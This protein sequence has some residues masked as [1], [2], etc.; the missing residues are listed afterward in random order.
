MAAKVDF[1]RITALSFDCYGTLIDWETG[2]RGAL[3]AKF[4]PVPEKTL[5]P[6][7]AEAEARE[8]ARTPGKPYPL[9]LEAVYRAL[10]VRFDVTITQD[11]AR[12]L[13]ASIPNWPAFKDSAD[14]LKR[15]QRR[16]KL[17]ILS[18]VDH[19]SFAASERKL[20]VSFD[21]VVTAQDVGSYK[22][23]LK[24]FRALLDHT[25]EA[26]IISRKPELLHVAESLFHDHVPAQK[27]G[28]KTCWIDRRAGQGGGA[29]TGGR[30]LA[31]KPHL[32]F[33]SL[34]QLADA[35]GV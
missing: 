10:A 5:F 28:L 17:C 13:G 24:N 1:K 7:F 15:L 3:H 4:G 21:L 25:R 31:V 8:E 14:A 9:I 27:L 26:K 19:A 12:N 35:A 32:T 29:S 2:L 34:A 16:F 11:D 30:K 33:H 23:D 6:A 20:G 18:N 22:P